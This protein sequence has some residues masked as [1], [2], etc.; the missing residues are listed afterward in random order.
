MD[1]AFWV[2]EDEVYAV[3]ATAKILAPELEEAPKMV[4]MERLRLVVR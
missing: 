2:R 3:N 4:T 1:A